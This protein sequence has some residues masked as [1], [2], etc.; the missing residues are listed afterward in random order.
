MAAE[1]SPLDER[2]TARIAVLTSE[3]DTYLAEANRQLAAY[4]AA[5]AELRALLAPEQEIDQPRST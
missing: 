3:R 5:I 1:T 4:E 2:I